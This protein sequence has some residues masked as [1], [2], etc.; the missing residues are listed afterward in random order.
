[1]K[2]ITERV[3][4]IV[5][6]H[7]TRNPFEL[8]DA[9]GIVWKTTSLPPSVNGF[10]RQIGEA[11]VILLNENLDY[12]QQKYVCAH[13][14]G[15]AI[16]H[17]SLNSLYM[18]KSTDLNVSRLERE[19]DEFAVHLIVEDAEYLYETFG[20]T[21]KFEISNFYGLPEKLIDLRYN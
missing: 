14:L 19:A 8:C 20:L 7:G 18:S 4:D 2:K 1:M 13:E 11:C 9:M 10:F 17:K 6:E 5:K 21:T 16:M 12:E 15:H 3:K